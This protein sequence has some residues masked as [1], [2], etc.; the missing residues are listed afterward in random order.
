[1]LLRLV[2]GVF[3]AMEMYNECS[4]EIKILFYC[5]FPVLQFGREEGL[6]H[7][8]MDCHMTDGGLLV[9]EQQLATRPDLVRQM[10]DEWLDRYRQL[11]QVFQSTAR[12]V[13]PGG[14]HQ[15]LSSDDET[16]D[17]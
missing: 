6:F 8:W 2:T 13:P 1:M 4:K 16:D 7:L 15:N 3:V 12:T 5:V 14:C 9:A 10:V 17:E 11:A